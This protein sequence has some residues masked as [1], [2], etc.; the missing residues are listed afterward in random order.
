MDFLTQERAFI[1]RITHHLN[2]PWILAH[3][4]QCRNSLNQDPNFIEIGRPEII[5]QRTTREIDKPPK[6]TLSD[7]IYLS[8]SILEPRCYSILKRDSK[9]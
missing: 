4:L 2:L 7:Y 9:G 1:F 3:G 6:G 8:I 5:G